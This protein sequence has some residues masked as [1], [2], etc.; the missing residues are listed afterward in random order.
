M[1]LAILLLEALGLSLMLG[2]ARFVLPGTRPGWRR[3]LSLIV[4]A[5]MVIGIAALMRLIS[6]D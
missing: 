5:L 4:L 6:G 2:Y 3:G 1:A